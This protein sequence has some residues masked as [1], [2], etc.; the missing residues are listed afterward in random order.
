MVISF[1]GGAGGGAVLGGRLPTLRA[2][3]GAGGPAAAFKCD[4]E[5]RP[6]VGRCGSS[7]GRSPLVGRREARL[8]QNCQFASRWLAQL[9]DRSGPASSTVE[10]LLVV[11]APAAR[12]AYPAAWMPPRPRARQLTRQLEPVTALVTR[13]GGPTRTPAGRSSSDAASIGGPRPRPRLGP[14]CTNPGQETRWHQ[15][16][17]VSTGREPHTRPHTALNATHTAHGAGHRPC[18]ARPGRAASSWCTAAT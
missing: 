1:A 10:D 7:L 12:V 2:V 14:A 16:A 8:E 13:P 17:S 11:P 9:K 18:C 15:A 3:L 5:R 4:V 6:V